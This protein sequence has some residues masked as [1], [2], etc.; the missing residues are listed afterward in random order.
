MIKIFIATGSVLLDYL[1]KKK[2]MHVRRQPSEN[3]SG[4][5]G[6]SISSYK[7]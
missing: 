4:S 5:I 6:K 1:K 7:N 3:L 2:K